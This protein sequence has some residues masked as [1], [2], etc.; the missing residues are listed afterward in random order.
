MPGPIVSFNEE[1]LR[2]DLDELVRRTVEDTLNPPLEEETGD[3]VGVGRYERTADRETYR[4]GHYERKLTTTSGEVT[5][6]IP[7]LKGAR[8]TTAIIERYRRRETSIEETMIEMYLAG[9]STRR[10]E[11]DSEILRGSSVSAATVSNLNE[12]AFASVKE[13]RNCPLERAYPY[14]CVDGIYPK[15][16]WGGFYEN[17]AVM[18]RVPLVAEVTRAARGSHVHGRQGGRHGRLDRRGVP[19]GRLP[20]LHGALLPQRA[21]QGPQVQA[22]GGRGHTRG[23]PRHG[24]AR[25]R[26]GQGARGG[27]GTRG[28]QAEGGRESRPRR[29][30]GDPGLHGV[31]REHWR[32]IKT[33][34]AI[35]RLN[36]EIRRRTR[37]IG[38]LPDGNS[39]LMLV[40][41]RLKYVA[42]SERGARRYLD[43]TLLD[44]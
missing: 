23:N 12:R 41:A 33:N 5:I 11:D 29:L 18:A 32:R 28:A 16:S 40:T 8:F 38:A 2:A 14:V 34:D 6:R 39:A 19:G 30:P 44:E 20:A 21:A 42:E 4:A 31:P 15:R 26:R 9:V 25:G 43:V 3:L 24:V 35:E 17:V 37:V 10:I 7:K 36:R 27:C 1:S 22:T 13:W